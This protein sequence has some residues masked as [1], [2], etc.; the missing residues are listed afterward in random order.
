MNQNR[1]WWEIAKRERQRETHRNS[2]EELTY[3]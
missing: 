2:S 3:I 1:D